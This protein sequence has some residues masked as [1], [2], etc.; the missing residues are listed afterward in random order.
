[1]S[2]R[3]TFD[4][5]SPVV[6]PTDRPTAV[7]VDPLQTRKARPC[8][9]QPAR[10]K[11]AFNFFACRRLVFRNTWSVRSMNRTDSFEDTSLAACFQ[12]LPFIRS[13]VNL[14][15]V[16]VRRLS[17]WVEVS[18]LMELEQSKYDLCALILGANLN[19]II[20]ILGT[21]GF[22]KGTT[23]FTSIRHRLK[24]LIYRSLNKPFGPNLSELALGVIF[25]WW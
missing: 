2:E 4:A 25:V 21:G 23:T 6:R 17:A 10:R 24:T 16:Y 5:T 18:P 1:M 19:T 3:T 8:S 14:Q 11:F 9:R 15:Y 22:V 20:G 7:K 13:F 12:S